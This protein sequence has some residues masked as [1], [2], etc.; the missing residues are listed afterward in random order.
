MF[1]NPNPCASVQILK[2]TMKKFLRSLLL[3]ASLGA[4]VLAQSSPSKSHSTTASEDPGKDLEPSLKQFLDV[5]STVQTQ[6]AE[7]QS[8]DRMIYEG[9]IPS[10]LRELDPHTQFFDPSQFQQLQ[11]M[12]Q[13]EQKGFGSVVSVLP[14]Q[15]I[16]LQTLPGTPSN[17][18][19]IQPG[20]EL[21]AV[22]N[23]A[24]GTLEPE[25]IIGLLTQARQQ[26]V[27]IYVRRQGSAK[28]LTFTLTPEL[29]DSPS[30][31]RAFMLQPGYGYIRVTSWDLDTAK[32]LQ[33]AIQKLGGNSLK[34]L[35]LDLRNN[36]GGVVTAALSGAS[37]FLQPGQ[38]ILTA[39]GR[40]GITQTADV[41]KTVSPYHF[42]VAVLINGKTASA[43]EI[44]SGALQ[45]HDRAIIVGEPSYGKGL[46][47]SVMPLSNGAG[48]AI[49][50]AF[51][52]T[53]SGRS[54]QKPLHNSTLSDTFSDKPSAPAPTYKTDKG[55]KV[56]GG[57][58]IQPDIQIGPHVRTQ[59]EVVLD[60]SGTFTSFAT[61][62]L[63][64]HSPIPTPF[65]ITPEIIDDFK[66]YAS[67]RRIQPT[68]AEWA[69][70]KTWVSNRLKEEILTQAYGVDK[71]DEVAAQ[72]DPQ[73]QTALKAMEDKT[74]LA[75]LTR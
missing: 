27:N 7:Q 24:I 56:T 58:G 53:P 31:D 20:D 38:R 23:I 61:Q 55:R 46:V 4:L 63:S 17:K 37:L 42:P 2:L 60:G 10:M 39:K 72:A 8:M 12:E 73:T 32:Q 40:T 43:S 64:S 18:A 14:G 28:I 62:Y 52:Y 65:E 54:I 6:G 11:E 68:V 50:T 69:Q 48:L 36:P 51:Y 49:T 47:Q 13:S 3:G 1:G 59:L 34:G 9:A 57:G 5:L 75:G 41:P 66:V 21:V 44:L 22:N 15:V 25:Q 45:D 33:D 26:K 70:E 67:E 29:V 35:V 30:V 19:G 74:L 71:G 16:F